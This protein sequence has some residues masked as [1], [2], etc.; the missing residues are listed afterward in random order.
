[1][2][3]VWRVYEH[4]RGNIIFLKK[5]KLLLTLNIF[6][7][8]NK[9]FLYKKKKQTV[10]KKKQQLTVWVFK[11]TKTFCSENHRTAEST[12]L[13]I[14]RV[15]MNVYRKDNMHYLPWLWRQWCVDHLITFGLIFISFTEVLIFVILT[16]I[17]LFYP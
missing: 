1:M 11:W 7:K 12:C 15:Q 17:P 4:I 13:A 10:C 6:T 8:C 9:K 5:K 14:H 16:W 3:L 2:R